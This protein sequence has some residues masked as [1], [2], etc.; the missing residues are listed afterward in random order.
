MEQLDQLTDEGFSLD[1]QATEYLVETARWTKFIGITFLT[2][3]GIAVILFLA[4]LSDVGVFRSF[5]QFTIHSPQSSLLYVALLVF[6]FIVLVSYFLLNFSSKIKAGI[7]TDS[8][9][10][11]NRGLGAMKGY[12][13][14]AGIVAI[15]SLLFT[16]LPFFT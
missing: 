4:N 7:E 15:L 8:P 6:V 10:L 2:C 3:C 1:R 13:V 5:S 12:F 16:L 9:E 11:I 14:I